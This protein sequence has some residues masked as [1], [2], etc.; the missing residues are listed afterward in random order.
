MRAS[1][2][3]TPN[4]SGFTNI[5][6]VFFDAGSEE[7]R[8]EEW[9]N[10]SNRN[11]ER[12]RV[13][14]DFNVG[15]GRVVIR[16]EPIAG[17]AVGSSAGSPKAQVGGGK[18]PSWMVKQK[19]PNMGVLAVVYDPAK[20]RYIVDLP[21]EMVLPKYRDQRPT[22]LGIKKKKVEAPKPPAQPT[23]EEVKEPTRSYADLR[24]A[25]QDCKALHNENLEEMK[26][27]IEE[28]N[29]GGHNVSMKFSQSGKLVVG[30]TVTEEL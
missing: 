9:K 30:V 10:K 24:K 22:P 14:F 27:L 23:V 29:S 15:I 2:T 8:I 28:M 20:E 6:H 26:S 17:R 7:S 16:R 12:A 1:I 13:E 3:S 21:D 25:L 11:D 19:V 18:L 5:F 4:Q